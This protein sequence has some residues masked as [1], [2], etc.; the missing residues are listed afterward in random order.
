MRRVTLLP[1]DEVRGY[2]RGAGLEPSAGAALH[3]S[4]L[5]PN[6]PR[7][8]DLAEEAERATA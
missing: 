1:L 7:L 8:L 2:R 6:D 4:L 5:P 3:R